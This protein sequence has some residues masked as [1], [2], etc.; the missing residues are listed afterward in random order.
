MARVI[1]GSAGG[2]PLKV[3]RGSRVRPTA[4]RVKE[5][6]FSSLG[7]LQGLVVLDLFAGTGGL[8]IEA[9]SRGAAQA[10]FVEADRRT[11]GLVRANL[12][13]AGVDDRAR[14]VISSAESFAA[15][16]IDGPFDLILLDP[17]Y[18]MPAD[19]VEGLVI[20]LVQAGAVRAGATIV[21]ERDR[22]TEAGM[23]G[24]LAH[25]RD[26]TYGETLLRYFSYQPP[27]PPSSS[28]AT[29]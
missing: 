7:P 22:H 18:A 27:T 8:G 10:V 6:L 4:D 9:L 2:R 23:P 20:D 21:L 3:P 16:P 24:V 26:R 13:L 25:T 28:E 5:A 14:V 12:Q 29:P 1:S 11:A 19:Q 15:S 17:P